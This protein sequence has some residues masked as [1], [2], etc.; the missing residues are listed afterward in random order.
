MS[1]PTTQTFQ[2]VEALLLDKKFPEA[3]HLLKSLDRSNLKGE[4]YG[5]YCILLT[6][7]GLNVGEYFESYVNEAIEI[8]RHSSETE[9]FAKAKYLKGWL[10]SSL[11]K[12]Y[13]A[14]E[15]FLEAYTNYLRCNDLNNAARVLNRL[16]Y[17][18]FQTGNV[19]AAIENLKKS[20]EIYA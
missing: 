17:S 11:G 5:F 8:F 4:E 16:S 10:F 3:L 1:I 6:E 12:H 13:E 14:K 18:T 15:I 19:E 9:K 20:L 7:A 2:Q